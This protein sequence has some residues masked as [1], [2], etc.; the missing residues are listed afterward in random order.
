M[1]RGGRRSTSFKPSLSGLDPTFVSPAAIWIVHSVTAA[2]SGVAAAPLALPDTFWQL[3]SSRTGL[4][5]LPL[6]ELRAVGS[7]FALGADEAIER[8]AR[9]A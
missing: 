9:D 4:L 3:T 8:L 5:T 2:D 6:K 1:P 7:Q